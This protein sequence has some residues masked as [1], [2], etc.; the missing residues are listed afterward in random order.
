[1]HIE[2]QAEDMA[3]ADGSLRSPRQAAGPTMDGIVLLVSGR[4][5]GR[6]G[7]G[8]DSLLGGTVGR[9]RRGVACATG[10]MGGPAGV[11]CSWSSQQGVGWRGVWH[12]GLRGLRVLVFSIGV[13]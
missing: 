12:I 13:V 2:R 8:D 1:M 11:G 3:K 4:L 7:I 6:L 9:P 10:Q 5:A